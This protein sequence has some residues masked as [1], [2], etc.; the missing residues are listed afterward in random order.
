MSESSLHM[1][2]SAGNHGRLFTDPGP[3]FT[4]EKRQGLWYIVCDACSAIALGPTTGRDAKNILA[5]VRGG[6]I[7]ASDDHAYE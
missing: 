3:E 6:G 1:E 7:F 4:F 5:L 2:R